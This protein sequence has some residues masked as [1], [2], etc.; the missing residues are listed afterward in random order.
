MLLN[1]KSYYA[2][3]IDVPKM[4]NVLRIYNIIILLINRWW[5]TYYTLRKLI[6][7]FPQIKKMSK[8]KENPKLKKYLLSS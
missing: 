3:N 2:D 4:L 1:Y 8:L 5:S 7:L 6:C